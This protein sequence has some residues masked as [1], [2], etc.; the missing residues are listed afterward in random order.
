MVQAEDRIRRPSA[1]GSDLPLEDA[2]S[3]AFETLK[4]QKNRGGCKL[5][6]DSGGTISYPSDWSN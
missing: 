2:I 6:I 4:R 3:R 1:N 5:S